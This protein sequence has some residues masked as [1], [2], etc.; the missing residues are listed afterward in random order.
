MADPSPTTGGDQVAD[1]RAKLQRLRQ[2]L[3]VDPY[4]Q[5][6][7]GLI[8]LAEATSLFDPSKEGDARPQ[9]TITGRVALHREFGSLVFMTLRDAT[10]DLQIALSKKA[11]APDIFKLAR[12]TDHG[13]I[14]VARGRIGS[15]KKGQITLWIEPTGNDAAAYEIAS[16]SLVPPPEKWKGLKD[17]ELR[18]RRRYVDMHANPQVIRTFAQRSQ[19]VSAIR[20]F[21]DEHGYLEVETPI[22]QAIAGGAAA[23]PFTTFH[24]AL[25]FDL[26]LR[27]APELYLKRLLVGGL[28]KV[29]EISRNFRNEG[30]DRQHNPEFTSMEVYEAFGDYHRM[31]ELTESLLRHLATTIEPSGVI[32]FDGTPIDY[33]KPFSQVTYA[34]LFEAACGFDMRQFD[35]VRAK[36]RQLGVKEDGVDDWLV[37]NQVF[38]AT[39]EA[40][41]IQ[42]TFVKDYP[43]AISPLTRPKRDDPALCERWDL[44]I[45]EMEI[46]PAYTELNDPD[47]QEENFRQQL[48][49]ADEEDETFRCLDEDFLNALRVGMPPAGGLGLGIDRIVMLLTN[50]RTIRDVI[51]FPLLRPET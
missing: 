21:M 51:L 11:V 49:G 17:A 13:D 1:R 48:A 29:Y 6:V 35:R 42:P 10:G 4:G 33:T 28:P 43:S 44:F 15:T 8:D 45:G 12:L 22:L 41:L 19:I 46:G 37:V 5:R 27:V 9:A 36:A 38:E 2:E 16:K 23:R 47:V 32:E 24:N 14:V 7:D 26:Y 20:N 18:Y 40:D 50:S 25:D 30:V 3:G 31:M 34:E 39:A